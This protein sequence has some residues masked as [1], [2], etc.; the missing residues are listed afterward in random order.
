MRAHA[1]EF[2]VDPERVCAVGHSSGGQLAGLLGTTEA[3][4]D[5]DRATRG[6]SSRVDCAVMIAGDADLTVPYEAPAYARLIETL[7]G[8]S[9]E[10]RPGIYAEASPAHHVD[11]HA[12]PL[13][14]VTGSADALVPH[15]QTE[16]LL[17]AFEAAGRDVTHVR[18]PHDHIS[19]LRAPSTW[20][21][22]E[23]FLDV[24][25]RPER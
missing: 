20:T 6:H 21:H 17:A 7:M 19:I 16:N 9:L 5:L 8:G 10:E 4:A 3:A 15:R 22:V 13:L 1:R 25:V 14:V 24:Q 18:L 23:R 11:E 12:A 2:G